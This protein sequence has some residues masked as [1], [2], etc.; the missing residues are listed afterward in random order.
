MLG[1]EAGGGGGKRRR[2]RRGRDELEVRSFERRAGKVRR[3]WSVRQDHF[4]AVAEISSLLGQ[5][6]EARKLWE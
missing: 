1:G 2:R 4:K 6:T 5:K 3:D